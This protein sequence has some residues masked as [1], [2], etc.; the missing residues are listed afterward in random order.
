MAASM[1]TRLAGRGAEGCATLASD[2][3][4]AT[5]SNLVTIDE[6]LLNPIVSASCSE[7][8]RQEIMRHLQQCLAEK[9]ANKWLRV[10]AGL[11][12]VADLLKRGSPLLFAEAAEG[13]HF[14]LVQRLS[15]LEHFE[16]TGNKRAQS[17]VRRKAASLRAEVMAR[18]QEASAAER[19]QED[20]ESTGS[21]GMASIASVSTAASSPPTKPKTPSIISGIVTIG[22]C[23]DT[24]S[25]SSEGEVSKPAHVH[26]QTRKTVRERGQKIS[27]GS[28]SDGDG[29]PASH[30]RMPASAT[31]APGVPSFDLLGI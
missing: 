28:P 25:E 2:L 11:I 20:T 23:D 14:D 27:G 21:P 7:E 12:V 10:N 22:H 16:H 9:G 13:R 1:W 5:E 15:F 8:S 29:L 31:V 30:P 17:I 19:V 24:T 3:K 4:R 26:N 18:L 6:E